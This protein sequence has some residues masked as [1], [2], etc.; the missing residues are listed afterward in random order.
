M[1]VA[2]LAA[3]SLLC[4]KA[5]AQT[6]YN[7]SGW[8]SSHQYHLKITVSENPSTM[9]LIVDGGDLEFASLHEPYVI[10]PAQGA[11]A[12]KPKAGELAGVV[13]PP[14][15]LAPV[16]YSFVGV[17]TGPIA[18]GTIDVADF[19]FDYNGHRKV[20]FRLT[21]GGAPTPTP[22]QA[23]LNP[24]GVKLPP[25]S[26]G[27]TPT[28]KPGPSTVLLDTSNTQGVTQ[29]NDPILPSFGIETPM[30]ITHIWTYHWNNGRG[31]PPGTIYLTDGFGRRYGPWNAVGSSGA[32]GA[33]NE[34]W[35]VSIDEVVPAGRYLVHDSA[36]TTWS[37]NGTSK[38]VGF[39]R[40]TGHE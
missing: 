10:E 15:T 40:V 8:D 27:P 22:T 28:P 21:N 37:E 29:S 9:V 31:T 11:K 35:D 25:P 6:R 32:N 5:E 3:C 26:N 30:H 14:G 16:M 38:N 17:L 7:Y 1:I 19:E 13:I 33:A 4:S 2:A 23:R 18:D 39:T 36:I 24:V 34:N 12:P 20:S